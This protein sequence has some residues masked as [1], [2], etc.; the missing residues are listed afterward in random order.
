MLGYA[1]TLGDL[2]DSGWAQAAVA[3]FAAAISVVAAIISG[4]QAKSAKRQADAAHGEVDPT[5]HI[6]RHRSEGRAP[7]GFT[8]KS[9]NFNRKALTLCSIRITTSD[10]VI[11]YE[12]RPSQRETLRSIVRAG[13]NVG[14]STSIDLT[15]SGNSTLPG[16]APNSSNPSTLTHDF[17]FGFRAHIQRIPETMTVEVDVEWRYAGESE[18]KIASFSEVIPLGSDD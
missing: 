3:T 16:V 1:Y 9:S 14:S 8:L 15:R 12:N 4:S 18:I 5:F 6:E 10:E 11:L 17:K 2:M 7:W 13:T